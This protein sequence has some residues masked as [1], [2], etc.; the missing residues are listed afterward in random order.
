MTE[1][2]D[3]FPRGRSF[4]GTNDPP[5]RAHGEGPRRFPWGEQEPNDRTVICS[6]WQRR[7]QAQNTCLDGFYGTAPTESFAPNPAGPF[8]MAGNDGEWTADAFRVR[9]LAKAAAVRNKTAR[10]RQQ[11]A[12]KG[13]SFLCHASYCYR[14]RIAVRSGVDSSSSASNF[15]VRVANDGSPGHERAH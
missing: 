13:G 3:E 15:R 7:L 1:A 14:S 11:K 6:I 12:L 5:I 10:Y 2:V 9:S 8:N 4:I